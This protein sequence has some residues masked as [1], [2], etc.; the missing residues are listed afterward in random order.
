MRETDRFLWGILALAALLI[1]ASMV[2]V[3]LQGR[4]G[5]Q[6]PEPGT[7]ARVVWD[8]VQALQD[9]RYLD[10]FA[11]IAPS[12]PP[13]ATE[14]AAKM[15]R[16]RNA[17][18]G[19]N[20]VSRVRFDKTIISGEKATVTVFVTTFY[21]SGPFS[22]S[23]YERVETAQLRKIEGQWRITAFFYP[24]WLYDWDRRLPEA[25]SWKGQD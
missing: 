17:D 19:T 24:Y 23:L 25:P 10:A 1:V 4:A 8:Y 15:S 20:R 3:G 6:P 18:P 11:L 14:F 21:A 5:E 12:Y 22:D 2:A 9:E 16:Q 7:P 13:D